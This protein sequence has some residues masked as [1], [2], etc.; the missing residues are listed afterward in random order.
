M[1]IQ[2]RGLPTY[3]QPMQEGKNMSDS[4]RRWFTGTDTGVP[5]AAEVPITVGASPFTYQAQQKGFVIVTGG[6]VSSIQFQR[7][8]TYATGQTAGVFPLSFADQL[9]VTWSGKPT[10]TFVPQ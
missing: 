4:W 7:V 2:Y 10:M 5:P 8:N 9:T 6:T 1:T 3:N